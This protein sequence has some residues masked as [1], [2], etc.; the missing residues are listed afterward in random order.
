[1]TSMDTERIGDLTVS[2]L[3]G[4]LA[5][6]RHVAGGGALAALSGAAGAAMISMVGRLTT[7]RPGHEEIEGRMQRMVATADLARSEFLSLADEDMLAFREVLDALGMPQQNDQERTARH[8]AVQRAYGRAA[9]VPLTVARRALELMELAEDAT[10]FGRDEA[11][12]EG[13]TG[14][15]MLFAALVGAVASARVDAAALSDTARARAIWDETVALSTAADLLLADAQTAF[16]LRLEPP[17]GRI[18]PA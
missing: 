7:D 5:D 15:S 14:A 18:D 17:G 16:L 12:S 10:A 9:Q 3:L 2:V 6:D 8:E 1:M 4:R 11:A 13:Y